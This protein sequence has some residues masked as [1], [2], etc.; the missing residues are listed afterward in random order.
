MSSK[1]KIREICEKLE[2]TESQTNF[3]ISKSSMKGDDISSLY[4]V[5]QKIK[6]LPEGI[7]DGL[8]QLV[9]LRMQENEIETLPEGI[10]KDLNNLSVLYMN[11][12]P[13]SELPDQL[14][15]HCH[16]L[17]RV[18]LSNTNVQKMSK[19]L[20]KH[21]NKLSTLYLAGN[22]VEELDRDFFQHEF[23][24][25]NSIS[26]AENRIQQLDEGIFRNLAGVKD[27]NLGG[28]QLRELPDDIFRGL[29]SLTWLSLQSNQ[30]QKLP[31]SLFMRN[32]LYRLFL[33]NND[34]LYDLQVDLNGLNQVQTW[35]KE[36]RPGAEKTNPISDT[37]KKL[38]NILRI[39]TGTLPLSRFM[40]M[41][42]FSTDDELFE[43]ISSN[44]IEGLTINWTDELILFDTDLLG[45]E[46]DTLLGLQMD[47]E[48][49]RLGKI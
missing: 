27:L 21:N 6:H 40:K 33:S 42:Q 49:T 2:L 8:T 19:D 28:N 20:F 37:L 32:K 36:H 10:F 18:Y 14:F 24:R 45:K 16:A 46:I 5:K 17:K 9:G 13:Y 12:N 25:L 11:N 39:S 31:E 44:R 41:M 48:K 26:L 7:F 3:V 1:D 34:D 4:L 35:M 23:P 38:Q 30:L 22:K 15:D 29:H 43:F 47:N